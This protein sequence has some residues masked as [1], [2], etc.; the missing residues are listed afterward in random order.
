[1]RT[2][3]RALITFIF[4][5]LL[6][7]ACGGSSSSPPPPPPPPPPPANTAPVATDQS[8]VTD[9]ATAVSVPAVATD[10]DGDMLSFAV[11]TP[12]TSGTAALASAG[13]IYTPDPGFGG[14]DTFTYTASDGTDTSA[15]ATVTI[16]V[17]A[18]PVATGAS[19]S[20]SEIVAIDGSVSATD[21]EGDAI[22][23]AITTPPTKG[24]V[25]SFDT[26]TGDFTYTPD[27][28]EDGLDSF[29]VTASDAFQDSVEATVDV[30]IF[31]WAGTQ[32]FGSI[33]D[34]L[35][36]TGGLVFAADGG[37]IFGGN[38][39]ASIDGL[40]H[41]GGTDGWLRKLDRRGGVAW[42]FVDGTAGF[43]LMRNV[44]P[45][46]SGDGVYATLGS[47]PM[48]SSPT[49]AEIIR[50]DDSGTELWRAAIDFGTAV[51]SYA[52]YWSNVASDGD[53]YVLSWLDGSVNGL[54]TRVDG[55][56]GSTVWNRRLDSSDTDPMSPFIANTQRIFPRSVA[57]D[58]GGNLLVSGTFFDDAMRGCANCSFVASFD[59]AGN[60]L[61]VRETETLTTAACGTSS[62]VRFNRLTI[63]PDGSLI[64]VGYADDTN[65]GAG[66]G[67]MVSL[68]ADATV[69]NWAYCDNTGNDL[70]FVFT[71]AQ[72]TA[73]GGWLMYGS[74][75]R[76]P[77]PVTGLPIEDASVI[78]V[79]AS[80]NEVFNTVLPATRSDG[81]GAEVGGGSIGVDAQGLIYISGSIT[82]E[83][84]PGAAI[85]GR[86]AF[87]RRVDAAGDPQ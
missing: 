23:Y 43:E 32:Q 13:F 26:A 50:V 46:P 51:P 59:S 70:S 19:L 72:P 7:Q 30:E 56:D 80:G 21:A 63:A 34:D 83:L 6:L 29:G 61:W 18:R 35:G 65:T 9:P 8:V 77:D 2:R 71:P 1:M 36:L 64:V 47:N 62:S 49:S 24:T 68:S 52:A 5:G 58:A 40:P 45:H 39:G 85:G 87:I 79:D 25:S 76:E 37:F 38:V 81:T 48:D 53:V 27:P 84:S 54:L 12:P 41:A 33:E 15:P 67:I 17:N 82:G 60:T 4:S 10:A 86:D 73:D 78:K 74:I 42:T 16:T 69:Q 75:S 22:T 28:A 14:V 31:R 66:D 11:A 55:D 57:M 3:L 44:L 20:T